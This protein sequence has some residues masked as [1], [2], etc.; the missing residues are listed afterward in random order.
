MDHHKQKKESMTYLDRISELPEDLKEKVLVCLPIK[1]AVKTS[2]LSSKWR[3]AWTFIPDLV[4]GE[5]I[6]KQTIDYQERVS[7]LTKFVDIVLLLHQGPI[8]KFELK[9]CGHNFN[10][11]VHRWMVILSRNGIRNLMLNLHSNWKIPSSFFN[12]SSLTDVYLANIILELPRS[13]N[14]FEILKSLQLYNCTIGEEDLEN[15]LSSCPLLEKLHISYMYDLSV[16]IKAPKLKHIYLFMNNLKHIHLITPMVVD[17][18]LDLSLTVEQDNC[19]NILEDAFSSLFNI[20]ILDIGYSFMKVIFFSPFFV[21]FVQSVY[22]V[23]HYELFHF[24]IFL[25][26]CLRE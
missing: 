15:L 23:L 12:A 8:Q 18:N 9:N 26:S 3:Y 24:A 11:A 4:F 7:K 20:E 2:C 10:D 5:D 16:R 19:E 1:E 25:V 22:D 13:C 14:G 21:A 6:V 17:A